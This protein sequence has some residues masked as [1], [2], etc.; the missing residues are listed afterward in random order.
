MARK[1]FVQAYPSLEEWLSALLTQRVGR[2]LHQDEPGGQFS[3][4]IVNNASYKARSYL[5]FLAARGYLSF[6]WDWLIAMRRLPVWDYYFK[7]VGLDVALERFIEEASELGYSKVSFRAAGEWILSRIYMHTLDPDIG[8]IGEAELSA[9]ESEVVAF[10]QRPDLELFYGPREK[11]EGFVTFRKTHLHLFEVV[12]YHRGQLSEAPRKEGPPLRKRPVLKPR[13]EEVA[14]R[15]ADWHR[16]AGRRLTAERTF[17]GLRA[18]VCW[19]AEAHPEIESFADVDCEVVLEYAEA[20]NEMVV[21][22]TGKPMATSTKTGRLMH[23]SNFFKDT[24]DWGW[25]DVPGRGLLGRGDFPRKVQ[26]IPRYIPKEELDRLVEA[27]RSLE[28]PYQRTALLV[29]RWSGAR[30]GEV[31]RLEVDCLDYYPDGKP[32]LRIP[33][34]KTYE[35]RVIPIHEEAAQEIRA[36]QE[37][38]NPER[39]LRDSH[40]GSLS[41]YLFTRHGQLL[42]TQYLFDIPL[43]EAC[44]RAGLVTKDGKPTISAHRFRHTVGTEFAEKAARLQTIMNVLGHQSPHMSMVYA[45]ISDEEVRK[46]YEAVLGPGAAIAG[47]LAETLCSGKLPDSDVEWLKTNFYRT[48]LELG[49]CLRL[50]QEGPCECDLYLSCAK[51]VTTKDYAPRLRDRREREFELIEDASCNGWEREVER[52]RRTVVRIEQ[53]LAELE[54]PLK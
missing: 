49:H 7:C 47:T 51:F 14:H 10:G 12:L 24:A 9:L 20:L 5:Y 17:R 53:L 3:E 43:R 52:H 4:V 13:M 33:A 38:S 31:R 44:R 22:R 41:R 16:A 37:I 54:E 15:Y 2:I 11:Y 29:T 26:R 21:P 6:D 8:N 34:G 35:E 36:L 28:C 42:S 18:F 32:R 27:I 48:E 30:R 45:Q 25:Q 39:G 46:D 50:P 23:L 1:R 19:S 40:T